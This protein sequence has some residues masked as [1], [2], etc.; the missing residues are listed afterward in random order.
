MIL[1]F[2]P[3]ERGGHVGNFNVLTSSCVMLKEGGWVVLQ[4][5]ACWWELAELR[6]Q[7]ERLTEQE[8]QG[9]RGWVGA[10]N[11]RGT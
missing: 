6:G 11:W 10:I 3:F 4:G 1:S 5:C 9:R 8:G 2:L 7:N